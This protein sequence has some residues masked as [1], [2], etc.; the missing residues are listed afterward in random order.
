VFTVIATLEAKSGNEI[1][2]ERELFALTQTTVEEEGCISY[3]LL[4]AV[5]TPGKFV[6]YENWASKEDFDR[7]LSADHTKTFLA[8]AGGLLAR[9]AQ[10]EP[11]EIVD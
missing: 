9:P 3:D 2:L 8:K 7:H 5:E 11:Y 4:R 10:I 1:E 6:F